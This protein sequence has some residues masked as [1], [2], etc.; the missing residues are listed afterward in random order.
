MFMQRVIVV[1]LLLLCGSAAVAQQD[2]T[3]LKVFIDCRTGCDLQYIKSEIQLVDFVDDRLAAGVHVLLTGQEVGSGGR[4]YQLEFHGQN[5][6]E[7]YQDTLVFV[8]LPTATADEARQKLLH[9]LMLGLAPLI[10]KTPLATGITISM[11]P[12][13]ASPT[14]EESATQDKWNFWV[15]RTGASGE[16]S[17]DQVYNTNVLNANVSANRTTN[18]LKLTFYLYGSRRHSVY[19][20]TDEASKYTVKNSDYGIFHDLVKSLSGHWSYGFQLD[21]SNNTFNNIKHK[22]YFNP[23]VEYNI[24]NYKDVNNR[25]FVL[26]YGAEV[27]ANA[28]YDTTIYNKIQERLY[29]HRA[30]AALTLNKKWGTFFAGINYRNYFHNWKLNSMG[31][32]INTDV[33]ITGGLSFFV[34]ANASLVHNQIS[35][36]K[37]DVTEQE[38]LTRKRQLASSYNY[39]TSFGLNY[40]FGSIL[41]N[42]VNPRFEGYG[43]F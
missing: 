9:H 28:Y 7:N 23:A 36:V 33:R 18:K 43:G 35:L 16:L 24:F 5:K 13:E 27:H 3:R 11:K 34:N 42:F 15:F 31:L 14:P 37:G 1:L 8:T 39:Y 22:V 17:A 29:G 25:F 21:Y 2:S 32:N 26:R 10:A 4:Q 12:K 38:V 19:T 40:R 6:Y 30:S 20:L 41:N